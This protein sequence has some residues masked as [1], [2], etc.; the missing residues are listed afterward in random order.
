MKIEWSVEGVPILV[1]SFQRV[2]EH[3]DD[4]RPIWDNVER[5]FHQIEDSQFKSEGARGASGKWKPLSRPYAKRKAQRWGMQPILRASGRLEASLTGNTGDTVSFKEPQEFGIGTSVPY[6]GYHQRGGGRLPKR[7]VIDFSDSQKR[8][9]QKSIQ[10]DI[11]VEMRRDS[12][13]KLDIEG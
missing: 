5:D 1:R 8:D 13:I 12:G 11:L 3:I 10:R 7:P 4:L 2:G 9:L 6:A